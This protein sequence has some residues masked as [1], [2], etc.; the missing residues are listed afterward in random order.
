MAFTLHL[1]ASF[2][3]LGLGV[4]ILLMRKGTRSHW[5]LGLA[6]V[7]A[8]ATSAL[9]SFWLGGG[10]SPLIGNLGPIH[11]LSGWI[12]VS[13]AMALTSILRSRVRQHR[14]WMLGAYTGL[15]GAFAGTLLPGRWV[16][17]QLGLW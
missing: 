4:P 13:L 1:Y 11:L 8:M 7:V 5:L 15:L 16:A 14:Q 9:S 2:L 10:V 6:W 3:A 12:L 17:L